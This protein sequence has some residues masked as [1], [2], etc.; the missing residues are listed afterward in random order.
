MGLRMKNFDNFGVQWK[1]R[2]LGE[3]GSSWKTDIE[4]GLP[5]K[6]GAWTVW[7]FKGGFGKKEG[8]WGGG[9]GGVFWGGWYPNAHYAR[10]DY[11]TDHC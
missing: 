2:L 3:G 10:Q 11:I 4:E 9:G 7:K 8:G 1:I 6:G 5:K